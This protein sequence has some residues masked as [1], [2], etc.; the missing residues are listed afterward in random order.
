M[1]SMQT[2]ILKSSTSKC[3]LASREIFNFHNWYIC[4]SFLKEIKNNSSGVFLNRG[5]TVHSSFTQSGDM[6]HD[7][8]QLIALCNEFFVLKEASENLEKHLLK[9]TS[10]LELALENANV[11]AATLRE[12]FLYH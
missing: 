4:W 2:R 6:S 3:E 11:T 5:I 1:S 10:E 12:S 8:D 9:R 7:P